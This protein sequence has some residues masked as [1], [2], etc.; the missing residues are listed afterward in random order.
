MLKFAIFCPF[1]FICC[2][3]SRIFCSNSH[4]RVVIGAPT[5]TSMCHRQARIKQSST[6]RSHLLYCPTFYI[7]YV[8]NQTVEIVPDTITP[9]QP[10]VRTAVGV[11]V[12]KDQPIKREFARLADNPNVKMGHAYVN[13]IP[14]EAALGGRFLS[15]Y[16]YPGIPRRKRTADEISAHEHNDDW[17]VQSTYTNI[18]GQLL[19]SYIGWNSTAAFVQNNQNFIREN[20]NV[21]RISNAR[22]TYLR[23]IQRDPEA[24]DMMK[25][26]TRKWLLMN[27]SLLNTPH[28]LFWLYEDLSYYHTKIQQVHDLPPLMYFCFRDV[29]VMPPNFKYTLFN[30]VEERSMDTILAA[31]SNKSVDEL[32]K[33]I[34]RKRA[35]ALDTACE[36]P[37]QCQCNTIWNILY[38]PTRSTACRTRYM[39][40]NGDGSLDMTGFNISDS[41]IVI[42]CSDA[43]GCSSK[44][45][46]RRCQR[47]Q[48]KML[49]A[50]Y[51]NEAIEFCL[52]TTEHIR[53][54]EFIIEYCGVVM[55]GNAG[56]RRDESY[57]VELNLICPG[58]VINS[59]AIGNL[60]R[61]MA[62]AC[63]P[64]AVLIETHSRIKEEDPLVPRV[65]VY[66]IRDIA[67]GEKV[68]ISYYQAE[69]LKS[70][71]GIPC[72]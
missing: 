1:L 44:C 15:R 68:E 24:T 52:R 11:L 67:A 31:K 51:E 49:V 10:I 32:Q 45:P 22:D 47:G 64:N 6:S 50:A 3:F 55:N 17:R 63:E 2:S 65:S 23:S 21:M 56:T 46:R 5:H 69:Q 62:H 20:R 60:S 33:S 27:R 42:E 43:C 53:Q 66:A 40:Q 13:P 38:A 59:A 41:R 39:A 70:K 71:D 37:D 36:N 30:V 48:S 26:S 72:K 29:L 8:M 54:G 18:Y 9:G 12:P 58:H 4:I 14:A 16:E 61:F 25:R 57:D 35:D 28:H 34:K 7:V 19:C